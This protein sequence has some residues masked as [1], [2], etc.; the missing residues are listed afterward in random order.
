MKENEE[1]PL[2][3]EIMPG[4]AN[5][6][7]VFLMDPIEQILRRNKFQQLFDRLII[8]SNSTGKISAE[9]NRICAPEC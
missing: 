8:G 4:L 5:V 6:K 3:A 7:F 9:L 2:V 1:E